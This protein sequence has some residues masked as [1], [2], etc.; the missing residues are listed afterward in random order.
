[1]TVKNGK[2]IYNQ[3]PR[4]K[5]V[6]MKM[7]TPSRL[8]NNPK[9]RKPTSSIKL[10][11]DNCI[12]PSVKMSDSTIVEAESEVPVACRKESSSCK[13]SME[14]LDNQK[15][16]EVNDAIEFSREAEEEDSEEVKCDKIAKKPLNQLKITDIFKQN[17]CKENS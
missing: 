7:E 14:S 12:S 17:T 5:V 4:K 3:T 9:S 2:I 8:K 16:S 13:Q 15:S 10:D 6:S 11:Y 1:M